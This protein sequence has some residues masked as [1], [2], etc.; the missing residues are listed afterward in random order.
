LTWFAAR[1]PGALA[2]QQRAIIITLRT[3]VVALA[4][5]IGVRFVIAGERYRDG[6]DLGLPGAE[7][8]RLP[9]SAS[10]LFRVLAMNAAAHGDILFSEPGMFSLNFWSGLPPPTLT[11]VTHWFS[12]ISSARQQA[13]I[14]VLETHP[15]ACIIIQREHIEYL[16]RRRFAPAGELHDYIARN[17]SPAFTLDRFEFCVRNQRR[18]E[19]VLLGEMQ[20]E[21]DLP[22]QANT[23][24]RVRLPLAG[25]AA[26]ARIEV[27]SVQT[28][29]DAPLVFDASNARVDVQGSS[30]QTASWPLQLEGAPTLL[31]HFDRFAL[32]RPTAGSVI[33]FRGTDGR[34]IALARL[35]E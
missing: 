27:T 6:S 19:P 10:A 5:L 34:E 26:I 16:T 8:L 9:T 35:K 21:S 7:I 20:I 14:R 24:L 30:P 29:S 11:N 28:P 2:R 25:R 23:T 12:L 33:T 22:R 15:R 4:A 1:F 32:P 18:I 17:F 13:I 3:G 31:I